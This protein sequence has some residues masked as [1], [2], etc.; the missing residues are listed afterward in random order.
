MYY[1][2][3]K[4]VFYKIQ[5]V[6]LV[7]KICW[8]SYEKLPVVNFINISRVR[9]VRKCFFAKNPFAKAK[10][11]LEKLRNYLSYEKRAHKKLMK[12]TP[13]SSSPNPGWA[14]KQSGYLILTLK[15]ALCVSDKFFRVSLVWA[16]LSKSVVKTSFELGWLSI[17]SQFQ[18]HFTSSF[19]ADI[20]LPK[21]Y[22]LLKE[23]SCKKYYHTKKS[24]LQNV[25]EIDT[26]LMPIFSY[27]LLVFWHKRYPNSFTLLLI[28]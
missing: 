26:W 10:T 1:N 16:G 9:F 12:S 13:G 2:N 4:L 25:D 11:L 28:R 22:K 8:K 19:C 21:N 7:I 5:E 27:L 18:Q 17:F 14:T 24:W 6:N 20:I 23:K 3:I 15:S